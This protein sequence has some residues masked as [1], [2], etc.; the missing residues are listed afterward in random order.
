MWACPRTH[1][2]THTQRPSV[3]LHSGGLWCLSVFVYTEL[4]IIASTP[5]LASL[6]SPSLPTR[7]AERHLNVETVKQNRHVCRSHTKHFP[8][9]PITMDTESEMIAGSMVYWLNNQVW[10]YDLWFRWIETFSTHTHTH[11]H[12]HTERETHRALRAAMPDLS[13][14]GKKK[15]KRKR[16]KN[17]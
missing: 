3:L 15:G 13:I 2:H 1:T 5:P 10:H 9:S 7:H 14:L 16:E 4:M 17:L 11:T 12:T 6:S 8:Q